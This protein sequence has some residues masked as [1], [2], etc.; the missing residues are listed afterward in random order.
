ME[1]TENVKTNF[2]E[3]K[4]LSF[5]AY[6]RIKESESDLR[7]IKTGIW[8][9]FVLWIIEGALRKWV[10]PS[11][12]TP[13]LIVRDPVAIWL[14][15]MA[16]KND[17][18]PLNGYIRGLYIITF[19]AFFTAVLFGHG[20]LL[21]AL[22]GARIF[23]FHVPLIFLIGKVFSRE[24]VLKMGKVLLYL[25]I[26][27]AILIY[28]QFNSPQTA[29]VN[30][31]VGGD[32]AGAG[33]SGALGYARPPGVFSFTT[34]NVEFFCFVGVF[35]IYFLL[36]QGEIKR[37]LIIAA[38]A[39]L[40]VAIP[41]S[42]SRTLFFQIGVSII[43]ALS[44]IIRKPEYFSRLLF[45][46][47]G[48]IVLVLALSQTSFIK[49]PVE[50]LT[51]R[52]ENADE[53][54]GGIVNTLSRV[55]AGIDGPF[56][57]EK[58][59]F[60]GFGIGMGT[61]AG[62]QLLVGRADEFLIAEGEW[63]RLVGE[64]GIVLGLTVILIRL[65]MGFVMALACF[66]KVLVRDLLPWLLLS[67]SFLNVAQAQWAQPAT[68]GYCIIIAGLTIASLKSPKAVPNSLE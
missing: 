4:L 20:N 43:F 42:I 14:L 44:S 28:F 63:G 66:K 18:F 59:P 58:L 21:V 46:A 1:A 2:E 22:Y 62:A 37:Y 27:M 38:T 60:F 56:K 41:F 7:K 19:I 55:T 29:F 40:L 6:W 12:S 25:S 11:F 45:A 10:F 57:L 67:I 33:F 15:F 3:N 50:A 13:L 48:L 34:G 35:V 9:Y 24:D 30:R 26:P 5:S 61:N 53:A 65:S 64:L 31:G 36:N 32:T 47:F 23:L 54:E 39:S 51:A 8:V 49:K 16:W 68:L 52:F 17:I